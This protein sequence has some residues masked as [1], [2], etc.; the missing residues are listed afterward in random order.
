MHKYVQE[1]L[2]LHGLLQR[3]GPCQCQLLRRQQGRNTYANGAEY[4]FYPHSREQLAYLEKGR[5]G[6]R[7]NLQGVQ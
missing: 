7:G 6:L 5:A 4:M 3:T 1:E 2:H